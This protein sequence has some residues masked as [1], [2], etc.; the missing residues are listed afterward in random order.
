VS[1]LVVDV[2]LTA[3]DEGLTQTVNA[4]AGAVD[5]LDTAA[6]GAGTGA[7]ALGTASAQAQ[8]GVAGLGA[9]AKRTREEISAEA[10]AKR[11]GA[12]E[13][14]AAA[15][16]EKV[17]ADAKAKVAQEARRTQVAMQN[18][19]RQFSDVQVQAIAGA[20]GFLIFGQ[21][22]G[23]LADALAQTEGRF[24]GIGTFLAGPWGAA[25][26]GA[27]SVLGLLYTANKSAG[28]ATDAHKEAADRLKKAEEELNSASA[29]VARS[30]Y[31][32]A[33]AHL[34]AA[35]AAA[36]REVKTRNLIAAQLR[37]A[38]E[39]VR[40]SNIRAQ[41]PGQRGELATLTLDTNTRR[42][43]GLDTA[44]AKAEA[45]AGQAASRARRLEVPVAQLKAAAATDKATAATQNYDRAL[46]RLATQRERGQISQD[47]LNAAVLQE[48]KTRDAAVEAA[49]KHGRA[50]TSLANANARLA[51]A[52]TD[53]ERASAQLAVTRAK[54]TAELRAGTI[55][56]AEYTA[57]V[58]AATAAVGDARD[59][60]K[61]QAKETRDAARATKELEQTLISI[62]GRFDP[63]ATAARKY[64][65]TLADISKL[66]GA[67]KI[68]SGQALDY[69]M[70]ASAEATKAADEARATRQKELVGDWGDDMKDVVDDIN[71]RMDDGMKSAAATFRRHGT[72]A[73][74]AIADIVGGKL[75]RLLQ[76]IS[77][78]ARSTG[79]GSAGGIPQ[80]SGSAMPGLFKFLNGSGP[81]PQAV[82]E[83][84]ATP[85]A[86]R[87]PRPTG[88]GFIA[89][90][91]QANTKFTQGVDKV[92]SKVFGEKGIFSEGFSKTLGQAFGGAQIG[93]QI[94]KGV[95]DALG[96]KGSK[97]GAQLGGAIGSF[98]PIPG[99]EIIGGILG[100]ITG[101]LLKKTP[102]ASATITSATEK[103]N[104]A[105]NSAS[106]R[107]AASGLAT[108]VQGGLSQI[109][110]A[111]GAD[112]GAFSV[113]I[114][115]R[116]KNFR[117][118]PSG[119]GATKTSRGARDFG[120]DEGAAISFAIQDAIA[121]GAV[122]GLSQKVQLALKSNENIDT[123]L[124][125]ALKVQAI[126]DMLAGPNSE[127]ARGLREFERQAKERVRIATKY[128]FDVVEIE[129]R[130]AEDRAAIIAD[131]IKSRVG[132]LQ[133]F[134][135]ELATGSLFEGTG[136]ELRNTISGKLGAAQAAVAAGKAGAGDD[137]SN[138][139]SKFV[140]SSR[141]AFGTAG[142]EYAAD[143]QKALDIAQATIDA[144]QKRIE[145]Q[146]KATAETNSQLADANT[147]LQE[148]NDQNAQIIALLK[149]LG[150]GALVGFAYGGTA[151]SALNPN[152]AKV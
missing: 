83:W 146:T 61:S 104:V 15:Q 6:K 75:G 116:N 127:F 119:R 73:A 149:N 65:D 39:E 79:G 89:G 46:A 118:D 17:L 36:E 151:N 16:A 18:V 58:A 27:V 47:Q 84:Y 28:D 145:D 54:A 105:G 55:T 35:R 48:T 126:E 142:T 62:Q 68:S 45:E 120:T 14:R 11:Q 115:Q 107:Q 102:N 66:Q 108:S 124:R 10:A 128:G 90:F 98:L 113:S 34:A 96:I 21:Q 2:S 97:M 69:T 4:A 141:D 23:Q 44:L 24:K 59:A 110:E 88:G 147:A 82:R 53:V 101:G 26:I 20:N 85:E 94:G 135:E 67:G 133:Q 86:E 150:A 22:A 138:L 49:G 74:S 92:F 37:Q 125:E 129:K 100:S 130:N 13:A 52:D 76:T 12:A 57:R 103:A 19:G 139:L 71:G 134:R 40:I 25:I 1:D 114:G 50:N 95:T 143:R 64:A 31:I 78:L 7:T 77:E 5:Q 99:G 60:A 93:G 131:E 41:A 137:L 132:G 111:L 80:A 70:A 51:A 144:E 87:G 109:A 121:D 30:A 3:R 42:A 81:N 112:I 29:A 140:S 63:A 32:E 33:N 43:A 122:K 91:E 72:D 152:V 106:L 136:V 38:Q 148:N 9:A 117:V 8:A 56:Q 123:A